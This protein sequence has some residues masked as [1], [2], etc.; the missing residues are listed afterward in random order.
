MSN[1]LSTRIERDPHC[2]AK[3]DYLGF[4]GFLE[5]IRAS[6]ELEKLWGVEYK[7]MEECYTESS[8]KRSI[9]LGHKAF[10]VV[11]TTFEPQGGKGWESNASKRR[12]RTVCGIRAR[13]R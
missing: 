10:E 3:K 6:D 8:E 7:L 2:I 4:N 9:D 1:R 11:A 12:R 13:K 5:F